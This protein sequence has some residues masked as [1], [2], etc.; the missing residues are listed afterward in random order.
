MKK[1]ITNA[2]G[3]M[4][5]KDKRVS[6]MSKMKDGKKETNKKRLDKKRHTSKHAVAGEYS[7]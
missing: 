5:K 6:R 4:M 3:K 7:D 1:Q 2:F